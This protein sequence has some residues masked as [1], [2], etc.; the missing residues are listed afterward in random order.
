[1]PV[2]RKLIRNSCNLFTD[3]YINL[4]N[5]KADRMPFMV[6]AKKFSHHS[7][8]VYFS[9]CSS[10]DSQMVTR[11]TL[12]VLLRSGYSRQYFSA[13]KLVWIFNSYGITGLWLPSWIVNSPGG[14]SGFISHNFFLS[15]ALKLRHRSC[16]ITLQ[17]K[18]LL[19]L[20]AYNFVEQEFG[21]CVRLKYTLA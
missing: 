11:V 21:V 1:M 9:D 14:T 13:S 19:I 7:H 12:F 6:E 10:S 20:A 17:L 3:R 16:R 2:K 8:Q 4:E 5:E 15:E 18:M